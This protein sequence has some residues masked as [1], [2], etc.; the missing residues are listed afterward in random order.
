[1]E[2]TLFTIGYEGR[3]LESFVRVLKDHSIDS[4]FDVREL[5]LS[6]KKGFSKHALCDFLARNGIQYFHLP[7]L[8]SPRSVRARLKETLDY[9]GFF[10]AMEQSLKAAQESI[11]QIAR[12]AC[13]HKS[14]LLCFEKSAQLCHRS[15][16]ARKIQEQEPKHLHLCNL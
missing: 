2:D 4:L 12:Y 6:R 16:V 8:G 15:L 1:M 14:C 3:T 13:E 5:P 11:D 10:R 9:A 7:R